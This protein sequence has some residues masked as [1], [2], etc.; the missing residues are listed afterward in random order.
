MRRGFI[1]ASLVQPFICRQGDSVTLW[2]RHCQ[3]KCP[4]LNSGVLPW[5][6][7]VELLE[8]RVV[9]AI[10]STFDSMMWHWAD[11]SL[12]QRKRGCWSAG[13]IGL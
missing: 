2:H 10:N 6:I 13:L 11:T 9:V 8:Q 1:C 3:S 5:Q 7:V 12:L 4:A